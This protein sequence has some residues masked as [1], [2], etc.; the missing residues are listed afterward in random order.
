MSRGVQSTLAR[1]LPQVVLAF[2]EEAVRVDELESVA[3]LERVPLM[4]IS[5]NDY[6]GLVKVRLSTARGTRQRVLDGALAARMVELLP[7]VRDELRQ[8][9]AF[10]APVGSPT[11]GAG[12]Q[13]RAAA[14]TSV[15]MSRR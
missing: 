15:S 10:A 8:H 14:A 7:D 3:S 11:S 2:S 1:R 6:G 12:R 9:C 13:I 5:V 4:N